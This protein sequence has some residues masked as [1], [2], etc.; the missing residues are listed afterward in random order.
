MIRETII[1]N[2]VKRDVARESLL[3]DDV[4][5]D[6]ELL[7]AAACDEFGAWTT[8]LTYAGVNVHHVGPR[9][10]LT[11]A[12]VEQ[13]LRRLC[14]TGYDLG[15]VVNRSRDR[16]L[17]EA[18]LRYHGTWRKALTAAGINLTNVSRRRPPHMDRNTILHWI[19][20]RHATGQSMTFSSVCL[21]NRDVALAIK[22]T[23]GSWKAA[24]VAANVE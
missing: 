17:Y 4:R 2:I 16:A 5:R 19:R 13:Q 18:A 14:T 3:E 21:E 12:R 8:A 15:A 6:D 22:R 9:R 23:F 20:E 11:Q 7:H 10:D 24:I 1:R